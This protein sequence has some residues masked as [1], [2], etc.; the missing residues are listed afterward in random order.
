[1]KLIRLLA[2]K[3]LR[4]KPVRSFALILLSAFMALS[5]FGGSVMVSAL[6]NGL[7]SYRSRL[8]ADVIVVP[9]AARTKGTFENVLLQG[10]PGNFYMDYTL[11]EKISRIQG[12]EK[13]APQFFLATASAG[14]C[15]V[16]VQV[17]GFD[18]EQD[19]TIQPWIRKSY[20]KEM[21]TGDIIVGSS[22]T[23]PKN[24]TLTFYGV[25]C[26]IVAV[27]DETGTGLDTAVYTNMDTI[28]QMVKSAGE[29]G[30]EYFDQ[31]R[32]GRTVSSVMVKVADGYD[33]AEVAGDINVHV[34]KIAASS[35]GS[36]ISG[37]AGGLSEVSF[38]IGVL[39]AAVWVLAVVILAIAFA[40]IV[41]E[42][43]AEFA[44]LRTIG[45]SGGMVSRLLLLE[46]AMMALIGAVCGILAASLIVFPFS[47]SISSALNLPFLLPG[48]GRLLVYGLLSLLLPVLCGAAVSAAAAFGISRKETGMILQEG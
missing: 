33:A 22:L 14:C 32:P 36:M 39:I 42:R 9:Y 5:V 17:I 21:E 35:A 28:G 46:A 25:D 44:V 2:A 4:R 23:V 34:R 6:S 47:T 12:V 15:S 1:M 20:S 45:A 43:A 38:I 19:F 8:G 24:K 10:I 18:P 3:N 40:M 16:P 27:L 37:I 11:Y 41:H 26:R 30:F 29:L 13:A 7:E 48:P 31:I